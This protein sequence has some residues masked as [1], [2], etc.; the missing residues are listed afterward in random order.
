MNNKGKEAWNK[1]KKIG[2]IPIMA[3]KKGM[4]PWNKGRKHTIETRR[5]MSLARIGKVGELSNNW[6]GG[7][8]SRNK[9]Y[10]SHPQYKKWRSDI[11][12][13][14]NWTCQTCGLRGTNLEAHHIK[15]WSK[16]PELRFDIN[17]GVTLCKECHK[18]TDN[19]KNK[20]TS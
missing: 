15:S 19:Y 7:K 9:H 14:D 4:I 13:R 1:G 2:Y 17:N 5:K 18:L 6:Q 16:Y 12:T 8:T 10:L 3:F 11:F 20:S